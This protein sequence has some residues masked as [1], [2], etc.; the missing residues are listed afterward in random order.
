M[1]S[2]FS[3]DFYV[4]QLFFVVVF[5]GQDRC[6]DPEIDPDT[7]QAKGCENETLKV[8]FNTD[9]SIQVHIF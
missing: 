6:D 1:G 9:Q 4:W 8:R 7:Q 3:C 2:F 5:L